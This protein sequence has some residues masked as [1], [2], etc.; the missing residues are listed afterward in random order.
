MDRAAELR[1]ICPEEIVNQPFNLEST[2]RTM[3]WVIEQEQLAREE[4]FKAM[5]AQL[6]EIKRCM[7]SKSLSAQLPGGLKG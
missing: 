2:I 7:D 3:L 4:R 6:L 5:K 1:K